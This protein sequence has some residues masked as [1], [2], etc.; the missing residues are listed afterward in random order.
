MIAAQFELL[1]CGHEL[2]SSPFRVTVHGAKG[3][4]ILLSLPPQGASQFLKI[5]TLQ[6]HSTPREPGELS[7]SHNTEL[8]V[9][10]S[11]GLRKV[12]ERPA[13]AFTVI[14]AFKKF[15]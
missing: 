9:E 15:T 4:V 5:P 8:R 14:E 3:P 7:K 11:R 12:R 6:R 1:K 10:G 2:L 13:F